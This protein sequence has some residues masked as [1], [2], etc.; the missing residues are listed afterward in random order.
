MSVEQL[1]NGKWKAR[2]REGGKTRSRTFTLKSDALALDR[3]VKMDKETRGLVLVNRGTMTVADFMQAW[4]K[5]KHHTWEA[6][7]CKQY[8]S[9]YKRFVYPMLGGYQLREV[10][11]RILV[12]WKA[13]LEQRGVSAPTLKKTM[14]MLSGMF[15]YAVLIGEIQ[16]NPLREVPKPKEGQRLA[17]TPLAPHDVEALRSVLSPRDATLVSVLGYMGLRPGEA[18]RLRWEDVNENTVRVRDTKRNRERPGLLLPPVANDLREWRL[19]SGQRSELVFPGIEWRN[20]RKRDWKPAFNEVGLAGSDRPY[21]LRSSFVSLLL[22]DP[23]Y[24]LAEV[25]MYAGHSL[26]I[27][28]KHYA[29]LIAEFQGRNVNAENEIANARKIAA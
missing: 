5:V 8:E 9:S 26:E 14:T 19:M 17:P 15:T 7:T 13:V 29:G 24:S 21:R 4:W 22:A 16:Y 2:Y 27:M 25:A 18:M 1:A 12:E 20:W 23:S 6:N 11:P 28:S 3:Q 10:E